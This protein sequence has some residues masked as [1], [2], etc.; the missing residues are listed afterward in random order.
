[1]T[2]AQQ[3]ADLA[4][5]DFPAAMR[6]ALAQGKTF[7]I[8]FA[9]RAYSFEDGSVLTLRAG[10]IESPQPTPINWTAAKRTEFDV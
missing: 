7:A 4:Q 1:M 2:T 3:I 6:A 5:Q 10:K 9:G 8:W